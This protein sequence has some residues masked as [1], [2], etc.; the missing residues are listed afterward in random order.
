M[1][2]KCEYIEFAVSGSG[3]Q[4]VLQLENYAKG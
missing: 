1:E 4:L 3:K 2:G